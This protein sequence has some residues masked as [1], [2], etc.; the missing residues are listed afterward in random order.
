MRKLALA[1]LAIGIVAGVLGAN[2]WV[3]RTPDDVRMV[4]T[5]GDNWYGQL[6]QNGCAEVPVDVYNAGGEPLVVT[7]ML[8]SLT[9][10]SALSCASDDGHVLIPSQASRRVR[11]VIGF[12]CE[13]APDEPRFTAM[14]GEEGSDRATGRIDMPPIDHHAFC[15]Y[16]GSPWWFFEPTDKLT[17]SGPSARLAI[18]LVF[19]SAKQ[20]TKLASL[21]LPDSSAFRLHPPRLPV[22]ITSLAPGAAPPDVRVD[23]SLSVRDCERAR[24]FT[25]GDLTVTATFAPTGERVTQG[26]ADGDRGM[27]VSLMRLV[28]AAC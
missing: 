20:G 6:G 5:A 13:D 25:S 4:V 12:R 21:A 27:V 28:E 23:G 2:W 11:A 18:T 17:G 9:K 10:G 26:L 1:A 24:G 22:D 3:E 16:G 7:G 8:A 14:V 15:Q 19:S